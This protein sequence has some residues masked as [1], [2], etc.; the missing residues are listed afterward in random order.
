MNMYIYMLLN[1]NPPDEISEGWRH[2]NLMAF[3]YIP[4][5]G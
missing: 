1:Q 2:A 3:E 4:S 5:V